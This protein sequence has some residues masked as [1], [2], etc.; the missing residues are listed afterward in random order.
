MICDTI[1]C[2]IFQGCDERAGL[3][4]G[5]GVVTICFLIWTIYQLDLLIGICGIHAVCTDWLGYYSEN[6]GWPVML[7]A[8]VQRRSVVQWVDAGSITF[9]GWSRWRDIVFW[10]IDL[11]PRLD[12][13]PYWFILIN[14]AVII[15]FNT[16]NYWLLI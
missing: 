1:Y 10:G 4:S 12:D 8:S 9:L 13:F 14:K 5:C 11:W 3:I 6:E 16:I 7:A 2:H 15:L